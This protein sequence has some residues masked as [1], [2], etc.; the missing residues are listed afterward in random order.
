MVGA[1]VVSLIPGRDPSP[2]PAAT[3]PGTTPRWRERLAAGGG[4]HGALGGSYAPTA[5]ASLSVRAGQVVVSNPA[6]WTRTTGLDPHLAAAILLRDLSA[7][8]SLSLILRPDA[9][10]TPLALGLFGDVTDQRIFRLRAGV[11]LS[12]DLAVPRLRGTGLGRAALRNQIEFA[13]ALGLHRFSIIAGNTSGGYTW[14]RMGFDPNRNDPSHPWTLTEHLRRRFDLVAPVLTAPERASVAPYLDLRD[15]NDLRAIA[16]NTVDITARLPALLDAGGDHAE[17]LPLRASFHDAARRATPL[18][19]GKA[20]L[21]RT[22]W[23]GL[24]D[25]Q[26]PA[27]MA[28]TGAYCGGW[29][30]LAVTHG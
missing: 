6:L 12:G 21:L 1:R 13:H 9:F 17:I 5:E 3:L 11:A 2:P 27:Q 22:T 29:K 10:E 28:R 23:S 15:G 20:L 19:L 4:F 8:T 25:L 7:G 14:A 24:L 30:Y 26:N 16:S 18:T